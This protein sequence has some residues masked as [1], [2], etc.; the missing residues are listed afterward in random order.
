MVYETVHMC[1][2]SCADTGLDSP[3]DLQDR[4]EGSQEEGNGVLPLQ[5]EAKGL[6]EVA[7]LC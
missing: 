3:G 4:T 2:V 7:H 1:C 6:G 5:Q